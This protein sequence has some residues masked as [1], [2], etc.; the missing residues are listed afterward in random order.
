MKIKRYLVRLK[1]HFIFML[2]FMLRCLLCVTIEKSSATYQIG[3]L[4]LSM[5]FIQCVNNEY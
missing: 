2:P 5:I 4:K 1:E 3:G